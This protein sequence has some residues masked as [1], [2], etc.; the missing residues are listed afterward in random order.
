MERLDLATYSKEIKQNYDKLISGELSYVI[1]TTQKDSSLKPTVQGDGDINEFVTE[2][3]E[4]AVQFG[5]IRVN[6]YGSDVQKI[7]LVGWCPDSAPLKS[8]VSFSNNVAEVGRILHYHVQVTAR[9]PDD[10]DVDDLLKTVSNASGARYSIQSLPQSSAPKTTKPAP[11]PVPKPAKTEDPAPTKPARDT[12]LRP[13]TTPA[14]AKPAEQDDE[15]GGEEEIQERDFSKKPLE[16]L[17]SAYK[18][19]KVD[20]ETLRKGPSQTTSSQP[21]TV[22]LSLGDGRLSSLPK[23]KVTNSVASKFQEVVQPS[24]GSKPSFGAPPKRDEHVSSG[25]NRN[26]G[27]TNGKTPAQLW[28]EKKGQFKDVETDSKPVNAESEEETNVHVNDVRAKLEALKTEEEPKQAFPPPPVRS[29]FPPPP[30]RTVPK[31]EEEKESEPEQEKEAAPAPPTAPRP[32]PAAP[33]AAPTAVAEY[34]YEAAEDNEIGFAEGE[35]IVDIKFVDEDWWLGTNAAGKTGL[36]PATYVVLNEKKD[37]EPAAEEV[38][39]PEPEPEPEASKGLTAVAEYDYDATEDNEI[40]FKE[41]DII[42]EIEQVDEDWWLG[43]CN[44]ERGLFPANY[45]KLQ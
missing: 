24:F 45:V 20:I 16:T 10:L 32:A 17:P 28:A 9:D 29:S 19:T 4:G 25:L 34:D 26:F 33:S 42:T 12:P 22:S 2:F 43:S 14:P 21:A 44:G 39:E 13:A 38:P 6:P 11:K 5:Y 1:Y 30:V 35:V 37:E 27:A 7:L 8:K 36:F 15:W 3:E 40:S 18:P 31:E 23:P 41:Q